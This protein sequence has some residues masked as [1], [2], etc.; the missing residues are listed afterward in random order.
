MNMSAAND[1]EDRNSPE[2]KS[3]QDPAKAD[4]NKS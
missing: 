1:Y 2:E 3:G 4:P